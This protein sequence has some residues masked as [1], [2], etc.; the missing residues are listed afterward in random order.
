MTEFTDQS[1]TDAASSADLDAAVAARL[2]RLAARRPPSA[3]RPLAAGTTSSAPT[4]PPSPT[5]RSAKPKRRHAASGA[6]RAALVLSLATTGGLSYA[7]SLAPVLAS[8]PVAAPG[9][10]TSVQPTTTPVS[11]DLA[12]S[13]ATTA[14]TAAPA[15]ITVNGDAFSNRYGIVQVQAIFAPDGTITSVST[16]QVPNEDRESVS[17]NNQAVP[18]L[19]SEVL[20]VQSANVDTVSGATY[21]SNDYQRSLQSAID[22]ARASGLVAA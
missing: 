10:V 8:S 13:P 17:I 5:N 14:T 18:I 16:L 6:R 15:P 20:T 12:A 19:N 3:P 9:I 2:E 21:T 1:N 11:G 22:T 7:M 4:A